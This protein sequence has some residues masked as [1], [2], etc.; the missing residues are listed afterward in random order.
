MAK[1]YIKISADDKRNIK[2]RYEAGEDLLSLSLKYHVNYGTLR[3]VASKEKWVKG[4][5][6]EI[7]YLTEIEE[8]SCKRNEFI[9]K[10]KIAIDSLF[11]HELNRML[12]DV[13]ETQTQKVYSKLNANEEVARNFKIKSIAEIWKAEKQLHGILDKFEE[14]E[15]QE[16]LAKLEKLKKEIEKEDEDI[17]Y[18]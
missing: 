6:N 4:K 7:I 15:Y 14:L 10:K 3:N 9:K 17:L 13:S 1:L 8:D 12:S 16:R 11:S 5:L 18:D 2:K